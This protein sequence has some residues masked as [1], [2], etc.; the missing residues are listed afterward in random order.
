MTDK[1]ISALTTSTTPLAGTEVLPIVQAG[2]TVS[3]PVS[4]LT[5][6][7]AVN[8]ASVT[9]TGAITSG[10]VLTSGSYLAVQKGGV[11]YAYIGS[12]GDIVGGGATADMAFST[13]AVDNM[14][15]AIANTEY[16]RIDT[17]GNFVPKTAAK[18]I[19]FT[20]NTPAAGMTSQLLNW[21]EEGTWTPTIFGTGV[22]GTPT[23]T[24][25][26][27]R[28]TRV[29]RIVHI[30]LQLAWTAFA[31]ATGSM[32]VGGLPFASN[33]SVVSQLSAASYNLAL[34]ANNT[35]SAR[36]ETS[37]SEI[38]LLQLPTGGGAWSAIPVDTNVEVLD[39]SGLYII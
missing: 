20:A 28:Y 34:T 9:T 2:T 1:R 31:G 12:A 29:G 30:Q 21:Y 3:V 39:I 13:P 26:V 24:I 38:N 19:N 10:A 25:Q 7:R 37:V 8:A 11:N 32:K 23:Y 18:G 4:D 6:G 15:F 14:V 33:A 36:I 35:L 27:G 16:F 22:A 17:S 5:A